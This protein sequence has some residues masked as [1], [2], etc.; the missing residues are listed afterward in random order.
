MLSN[1]ID[2]HKLIYHPE[3]VTHWMK[4]GDC[5]PVYVEIGLTDKCNHRCIYCALDW[6]SKDGLN[7]EK[8]IMLKTL[9]D[10]ASNGVKAVMFAGEGEPLLHANISAFVRH[11]KENGL[12]VAITTNGVLF[13][14]EEAEECLPYLSWIR[15]S[16]DAGDPEVYAR[17]HRIKQEDLE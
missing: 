11:A 7:I 17:V 16:V 8:D 5:F 14:R 9:E 12:A 3:C 4:N 15:F 1:E 13:N 6:L 10:L 2:N